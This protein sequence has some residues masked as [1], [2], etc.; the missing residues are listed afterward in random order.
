MVLATLVRVN[1][2][3]GPSLMLSNIMFNA[4]YTVVI[5]WS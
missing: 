3:I 1:F 2:H 5:L 4:K